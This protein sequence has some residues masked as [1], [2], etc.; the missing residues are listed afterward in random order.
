MSLSR[1]SMDVPF[2]S[3]CK[4]A[5]LDAT[6]VLAMPRE[7]V[8]KTSGLWKDGFLSGSCRRILVKE[9]SSSSSQGSSLNIV[10]TKAG[11]SDLQKLLRQKAK[12]LLYK[13]KKIHRNNFKYFGDRQKLILKF[14]FKGHIFVIISWPSPQTQ[15]ANPGAWSFGCCSPGNVAETSL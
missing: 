15:M 14:G 1:P 7:T 10:S 13:V 11:R 9:A 4:I 3:S 2:A 8:W 5:K 6:N 12:A